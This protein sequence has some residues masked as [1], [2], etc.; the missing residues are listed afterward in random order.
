MPG[1]LIFYFLLQYSVKF[2]VF[3]Y[4]ILSRLIKTLLR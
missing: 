3:K 1:E 4:K 2:E